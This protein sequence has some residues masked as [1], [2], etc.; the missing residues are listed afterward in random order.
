MSMPPEPNPKIESLLKEWAQ[1]RRAQTGEFELHPASRNLL[2]GE[3]ARVHRVRELAERSQPLWRNL[4]LRLALGGG[5]AVGIAAAVLWHGNNPARMELAQNKAASRP[6]AAP[7]HQ[8]IGQS[9]RKLATA[10]GRIESAAK[11]LPARPA[12]LSDSLNTTEPA[13]TAPMNAPVAAAS[14]PPTAAAPQSV[15]KETEEL[16]AET[17][18]FGALQGASQSKLKKTEDKPAASQPDWQLAFRSPIITDKDARLDARAAGPE[19]P[20]IL[21]AFIVQRYGQKV[22]VTESDGSI[23]E[24]TLVNPSEITRARRANP[25]AASQEQA[26]LAN[27]TSSGFSFRVSGTSKRL[28][29]PVVFIASVSPMERPSGQAQVNRN[30]PRLGGAGDRSSAAASNSVQKTQISGQAQISGA[31]S[32][33]IRAQSE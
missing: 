31:T 26:A 21:T 33:T 29:R 4:W 1:K 27:P 28:N 32:I 30:N 23:Y 13:P 15:A 3:V 24:G 10:S 6:L 19:Q 5:L 20:A 22:R 8:T 7:Q 2:Q 18:S 17:R 25:T 9:D 12:T 11:Q 16:H 14:P